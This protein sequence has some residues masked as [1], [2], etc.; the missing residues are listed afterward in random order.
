LTW[1]AFCLPLGFSHLVDF[2]CLS[3]GI[4]VLGISFEFFSL[5]SSF[6]QDAL[7]EHVHHAKVLMKLKD[8]Q[9]VFGI[10]F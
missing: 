9:V 6:L 7:D 1:S 2:C 4:R 5:F 8:V 3:N 10:L